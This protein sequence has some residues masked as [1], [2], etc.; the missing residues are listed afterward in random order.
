MFSFITRA[1]EKEDLCG[2]LEVLGELAD[3]AQLT[4][5]K[6]EQIFEKI[7]SAGNTHIFVAL[8]PEGKVVGTCSIIIT[9][10]FIHNGGMVGHLEDLVVHHDFR[11]MGI[12]SALLQSCI[13]VAE[14]SGCYKTMGDARY[15]ALCRKRG[16]R[17]KGTHMVIYHG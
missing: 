7:T 16:M 5:E 3:T 17:R 1:L 13:S 2:F 6:A 8:L 12:A 9:Q 14:L 4:Q 11:K 10:R 15:P